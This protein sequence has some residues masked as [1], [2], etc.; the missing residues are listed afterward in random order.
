MVDVLIDQYFTNFLQ[1]S[2]IAAGEDQ[3]ADLWTPVDVSTPVPVVV[4]IHGGFW[5]QQFA[6]DLMNGLAESLGVKRNEVVPSASFI[7]DLNAAGI[8]IPF[9]QRVIHYADQPPVDSTRPRRPDAF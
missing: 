6:L 3:V 1:L 9:P 7:D 5:R 4:L 2:R 8:A